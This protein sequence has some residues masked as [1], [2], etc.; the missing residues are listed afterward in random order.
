MELQSAVKGSY[1]KSSA[2]QSQEPLWG[3]KGIPSDGAP[4]SQRSQLGWALSV[5]ALHEVWLLI[6]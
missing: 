2:G 6:Q 1:C 5:V 3:E 4:R